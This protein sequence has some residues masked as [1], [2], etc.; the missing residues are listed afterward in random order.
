[1]EAV[2]RRDSRV[3]KGKELRHTVVGSEIC[4]WPEEWR[5]G[6]SQETPRGLE[7]ARLEVGLILTLEGTTER[8]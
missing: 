8:L 3:S 6:R 7:P 5:K 1:M 2:C 4:L